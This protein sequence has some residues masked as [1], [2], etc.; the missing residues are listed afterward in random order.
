MN[1]LFSSINLGGLELANRIIIPPM[2]QYSADEGRP[3]QW[4][5]MHYG[6]LAVSG[7]GLLIV[8]AT[9]VEPEGRISLG[10]LG[11]WS[12]EHEKLHKGMLDFIGAFSSTPVAI[13]LGHSGR[14]GST[15]R[16]WEGRGPLGLHEGGWNVCAPSPLPFDAA[17]PTPLALSSGDIDRLT[18]SFVAAAQRAQR[19]GYKAVELHAAHGYLL[20]EFLSPLTNKR[21]DAYGGSLENRMRLPLQVFAA[22]RKALPPAMPVGMRVSGTDFAPG[23]WD[24]Q[25]CAVLAQQLE[26]AGGAFIHVSGGGLTPEQKIHLAPGYQVHLAQ[27]IKQAVENMP[28][29]AVG[30]ITEPEL[31]AGIIVTGQADMVAVGRAM[32]YDPR[33]PWHAAAALGVSIADTPRQYLRCQP[34]RLKNLFI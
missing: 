19:A 5:H 6:H 23:G 22:V 25:E 11:L 26:K 30:L 4:H 24:V 32:M 17:S 8:E 16:P 29:I 7:A 10:D 1:T 12:D 18:A 9:A 33:W 13:Q 2:D 28:V 14:K 3:S 15:A 20:H 27:A 31:A 34:H 21:E